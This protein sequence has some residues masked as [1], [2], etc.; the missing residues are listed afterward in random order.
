MVSG[1]AVLDSGAQL[2]S[3]IDRFFAGNGGTDDW[4]ELSS[5]EFIRVIQVEWV[6]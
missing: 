4:P 3:V 5:S 2:C 1:R 6:L